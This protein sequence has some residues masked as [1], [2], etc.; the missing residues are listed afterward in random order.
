MLSPRIWLFGR[1]KPARLLCPWN[2]PCKNT[3]VG[4]PFLLQGIFLTQGCNLRLLRLLIGRR[5][6]YHGFLGGTSD[7][8]QRH[9]FNPWVRKIP[10][11][12]KGQPTPVFLP[13]ELRGQRSLAGYNPWGCK[14]LDTTEWLSYTN[15]HTRVHHLIHTKFFAFLFC[16]LVRLLLSFMSVTAPQWLPKFVMR[17]NLPD[18]RLIGANLWCGQF[19]SGRQKKSHTYILCS[20]FLW[21]ETSYFSLLHTVRK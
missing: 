15:T 1:L 2:F 9:G 6:L 7:K 4:C 8:E 5:I 12:R 20:G 19:F 16:L 18:D 14:E 17:V 3:G 11:R 13:G 10:W 21:P